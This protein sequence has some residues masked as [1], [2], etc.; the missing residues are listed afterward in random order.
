VPAGP[1]A[2]RSLFLVGDR[3]AALCVVLEAK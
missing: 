1:D 2:L 3:E